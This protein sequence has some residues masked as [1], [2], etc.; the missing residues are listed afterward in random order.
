MFCGTYPSRSQWPD[1][2]LCSCLGTA[3][4]PSLALNGLPQYIASPPTEGPTLTKRNLI[5]WIPLSDT[6]S[7]QFMDMS[8]TVYPLDP[9]LFK[10]KPPRQSSHFIPNNHILIHLINKIVLSD[11]LPDSQI[12][13]V[14]NKI[15][16][17]HNF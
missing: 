8:T 16:R 6:Y 7:H 12:T 15:L 1:C 3:N 2:L 17:F 10:M 11:I 4:C 9:A 5:R 14:L 13:S